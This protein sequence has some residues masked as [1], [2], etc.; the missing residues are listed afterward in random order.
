MVKYST[1]ANKYFALEEVIHGAELGKKFMKI[2]EPSLDDNN[3]NTKKGIKKI[4]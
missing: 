2:N 3:T 4:I 1:M